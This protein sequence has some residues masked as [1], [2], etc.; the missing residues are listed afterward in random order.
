MEVNIV[1]PG[2][3]GLEKKKK[4]FS[5]QGKE[6]IHVLADFDRTLT[7]AYVNGEYIPSTIALLRNKDYINKDYSNKARAL[8][9]KYHPIEKNPNVSPEEKKEKMEEWWVS[10]FNLLIKS[11]LNKKH[12]EKIVQSEEIQF[13]KGALELFDILHKAKIPMVIISSTGIGDVIPMLFEREGKLYD[14]IHF[15]TNL[16]QWDNKG[17]AVWIKKQIITSMNKD[18]TSIQEYPFFKQIKNRKNVLLLG[19]SIGDLGMVKGFKYN[20][21]IKIGFLNDEIEKN[22][23]DYSANFDVVMLNDTNMNYVTELAKGIIK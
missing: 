17:R 3:K 8:A 20:N 15:I 14:N 18:E 12:L 6:R 10:H 7:K 11:G 23:Q 22:I 13:R 16:Y 21:L 4:I 19:D 2:R 1:I 5:E 9:A